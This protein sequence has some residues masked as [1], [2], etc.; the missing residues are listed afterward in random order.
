MPN[1]SPTTTPGDARRRAKTITVDHPDGGAPSVTWYE[2]DRINRLDGSVS[3]EPQG[4]LVSTFFP[5][6]M[7]DVIPLEDLDTGEKYGTMTRAQIILAVQALY[8]F[9]AVGRDNGMPFPPEALQ[10]MMD[11]P[12]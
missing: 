5:S 2:E 3:Y 8:K 6:Q 7:D 4:F 11:N 10:S 1:Y 12:P 9:D